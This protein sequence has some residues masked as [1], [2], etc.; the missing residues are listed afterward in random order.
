M[1]SKLHISPEVQVIEPL[2]FIL[3]LV[4]RHFSFPEQAD[5]CE[6]SVARGVCARDSPLCREGCWSAA[7][8]SGRD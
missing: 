6:L 3:A 2:V 5:E 8:A 7:R 4:R 1:R